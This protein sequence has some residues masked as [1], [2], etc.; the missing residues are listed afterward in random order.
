[1]VLFENMKKCSIEYYNMVNEMSMSTR[2]FNIGLIFLT[3][4]VVITL[5][6]SIIINEYYIISWPWTI[7]YLIFLLGL[8][9]EDGKN[10]NDKK[11]EENE[12]N[13]SGSVNSRVLDY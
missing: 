8:R 11:G 9:V 3:M 10:N 12:K 2:T 4:M 6:I 7:A 13:E 5:S 1:M